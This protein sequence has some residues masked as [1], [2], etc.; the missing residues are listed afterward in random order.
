MERTLADQV[1]RLVTVEE[2]TGELE[3]VVH[4]LYED[5]TQ[6]GQR[7]VS[8]PVEV[9]KLRAAVANMG[10][11]IAAIEGAQQKASLP[12]D[13]EKQVASNKLSIEAHRKRLVHVENITGSSECTKA[14]KQL[15]VTCTD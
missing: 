4:Q 6:G 5:Y 12:K 14:V 1:G 10:T 8:A 9:K 2:R 11:Q 15:Q 13:L 3:D 7:H